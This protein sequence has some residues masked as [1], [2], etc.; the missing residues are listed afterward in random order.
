M[1]LFRVGDRVVPKSGV[2][3]GE[4]FKKYKCLAWNNAYVVIEGFNGFGNP[5]CECRD[6]NTIW[7]FDL[8]EIVL[9]TKKIER[10]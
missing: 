8:N 10:T 5:I 2:V 3:K 4:E 9:Y 6:R 1:R 7:I